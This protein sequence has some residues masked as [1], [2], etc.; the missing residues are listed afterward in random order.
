VLVAALRKHSPPHPRIAE[1]G[2]AG[3]GVLD[4]VLEAVRPR[5]YHIV[6]SNAFGLELLRARQDLLPILHLHEAD[7]LSL[8]LSLQ[9][10]VVFSVGLIEH[11]DEEGTRHAV[12]AHFD[13]LRPGGIAIISYPTP[14]LLYRAIRRA[15]EATG[16][17]IFHDERPLKLEEVRML[18]A[19]HGELLSER[20]IWPIGLTQAIVVV[21]KRDR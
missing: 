4:A 20:I 18:A 1:L 2:G 17:W 8:G 13:L 6:D 11:F 19:T 3:G 15:S 10:D 9:L 21:R 12:S 14:T 16:Q 5:E 7:V